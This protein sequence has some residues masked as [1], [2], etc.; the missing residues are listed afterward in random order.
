MGMRV[1]AV[2]RKGAPLYNVD[3]LVTKIYSPADR[4]E[5]IAECDYVAVAAPMTPETRG[6]IGEAEFAAMKPDAV[7]LNVG[8]GP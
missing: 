4:L 5:M 3:P 7:I 2:K 8:R 1:L 6:M